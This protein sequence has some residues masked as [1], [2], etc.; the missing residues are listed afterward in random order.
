MCRHY[1]ANEVE[2]Q[3]EGKVILTAAGYHQQTNI[4]VVGF[5]NGSFYLY[6]MPDVN[7]IHSLRY[8]LIQYIMLIVIV[9][10]IIQKNYNSSLIICISVILQHIKSMYFINCYKYHWRLDSLRLFYSWSII[11]MGVAK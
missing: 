4:L 11:S 1:L 8:C 7:M 6:E 9:Y 3:E 10:T 2:K 5:S